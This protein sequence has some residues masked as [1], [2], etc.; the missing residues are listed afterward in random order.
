MCTWLC[1]DKKHKPKITLIFK[2][3]QNSKKIILKF[4]ERKTGYMLFYAEPTLKHCFP[5]LGSRADRV[6]R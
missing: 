4:A 6:Q 5:L 3:K 2:V 1:L